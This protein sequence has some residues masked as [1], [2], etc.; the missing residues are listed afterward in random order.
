M[1][2]R[3]VIYKSRDFLTSES[4]THIPVSRAR[5]MEIVLTCIKPIPMKSVFAFAALL[6]VYTLTAMPTQ[7]I[8]AA[9]AS[10]RFEI[11][12]VNESCYGQASGSAIVHSASTNW[13]MDIY[14]NGS[15]LIT[16][17]ITNQDTVIHDLT[18]GCYSFVCNTGTGT[19][20]T[21][22]K[23][24]TGPGETRSLCRVH[25][26]NRKDEDAVTFINLSSGAVSFAWDFGDGTQSAEISPT[27]VYSQPGTYTVT[28]TASNINGCAAVSSYVVTIPEERSVGAAA[29]LPSDVLVQSGNG[30]AHIA[31]ESEN[32]IEQITVF[33]TGGDVIFSGYGNNQEFAYPAPGVYLTRIVYKDG[34]QVAAHVLLN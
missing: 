32:Q 18:I 33:S 14:R 20:E 23:I 8:S 3:S 19:T 13:H 2:C 21:L 9:T 22:S 11:Q 24:I 27:H 34:Q 17:A 1:M 6:S 26:L 30:N 16:C 4:C 10:P 15:L 29:V 28:L 12:T 31:N 7:H 5:T 25:Y